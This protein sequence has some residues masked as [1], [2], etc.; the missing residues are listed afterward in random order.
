M[1]GRPSVCT[2]TATLFPYTTAF[3]S[4]SGQRD[5]RRHDGS[6]IADHL[7]GEFGSDHDSSWGVATISAA[8][9]VP[10]APMVAW[11]KTSASTVTSI[12]ADDGWVSRTTSPAVSGVSWSG[13]KS[14]LRRST[15][16]STGHSQKRLDRKEAVKGTSG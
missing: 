12:G 5:R 6:N 11:A 14:V 8:M 16:T 15:E 4:R 2:R 9:R 1:I 3:R 10:R 7:L 13:A